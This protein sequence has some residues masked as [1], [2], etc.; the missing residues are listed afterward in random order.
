MAVGVFSRHVTSDHRM[1]N[2]MQE[3]FD[4]NIATLNNY[5]KIDG[6]ATR[7]QFWYFVLFNWLVGIGASILDIFVPGNAL[8]NL[9]SALL[10]IPSITV[11]IRRMHDSDHSGWWLLFPIV[12]LIFLISESKP[13]RWSAAS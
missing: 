4:T 11:G 3:F 13:N 10:F 12:N 7:R 6:T 9:V 2:V 5:F 1:G 8:A